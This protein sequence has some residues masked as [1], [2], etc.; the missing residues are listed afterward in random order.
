MERHTAL[1][2]ARIRR[3]LLQKDLATQA[4]CSQ[5]TVVDIESG[6]I[7]KSKYLPEVCAVLGLDYDLLMADEVGSA[8]ELI[9][10]DFGSPVPVVSH[11]QVV[12]WC[13][14]AV[15]DVSEARHLPCPVPHSKRTF[16]LQASG[17]SMEP[18]ICH[19]DFVHVDPDVTCQ[20]GDIACLFIGTIK[21]PVFRKVFQ[22]GAQWYAVTEST[23]AQTVLQSA[24]S[25]DDMMSADLEG[26]TGDPLAYI[27]GKV[28]YSGRFHN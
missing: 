22:E 24:R 16:A 28:L 23:G 4:G 17:K 10:R 19:G 15:L 7:K 18:V 8:N 13:M 26:M 20:S 6:K 12:H 25:L 2:Q 27:A 9:L 11:E 21:A 14:G 3:G 1:K 5:Q